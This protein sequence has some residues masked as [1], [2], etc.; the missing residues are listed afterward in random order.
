MFLFGEFSIK[1]IYKGERLTDLF[2]TLRVGESRGLEAAVVPG[3]IR[4][5]LFAIILAGIQGNYQC[6][7]EERSFHFDEL[8]RFQLKEVTK[9]SRINH[10]LYRRRKI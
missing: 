6:G 3:S 4:T 5:G 7:K 8:R 10:L 1:A 2:H 9:P